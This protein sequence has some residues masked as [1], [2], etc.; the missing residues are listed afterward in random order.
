LQSPN[1]AAIAQDTN[2]GIAGVVR[3]RFGAADTVP[4]CNEG[5]SGDNK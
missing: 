4:N 3:G 5:V 1:V 2:G